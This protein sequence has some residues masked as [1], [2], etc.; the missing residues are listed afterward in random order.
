MSHAQF[1]CPLHLHVLNQ[2]SLPT[3]GVG[4]LAHPLS[5]FYRLGNIMA[6]FPRS[7]QHQLRTCISLLVNWITAPFH[8]SP[9]CGHLLIAGNL[10]IK[11]LVARQW[12]ELLFLIEII[13]VVKCSLSPCPC[14]AAHTGWYILCVTLEC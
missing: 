5:K 11:P 13:T 9:T 4:F 3:V 6:G 10:P 12:P 7:R 1:C 8:H 14:Y 2:I